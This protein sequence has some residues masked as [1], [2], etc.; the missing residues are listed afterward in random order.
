M[1]G[2]QYVLSSSYFP[3]LAALEKELEPKLADPAPIATLRSAM[4]ADHFGRRVTLDQAR[5]SPLIDLMHLLD[6]RYTLVCSMQCYFL[7]HFRR[8]HC[9]SLFHAAGVETDLLY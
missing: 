9:L 5:K 3:G 4:Y 1:E 2:D 7:L 6:H 8:D